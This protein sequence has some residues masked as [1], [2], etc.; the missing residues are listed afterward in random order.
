MFSRE[1]QAKP[2]FPTG[3]LGGVPTTQLI[4]PTHQPHIRESGYAHPPSFIISPAFDKDEQTGKRNLRFEFFQESESAQLSKRAFSDMSALRTADTTAQQLL[5][6][7]PASIDTLQ[8]LLVV[9][10]PDL[11]W[12]P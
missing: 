7:S 10:S 1:S 4:P 11:Q 12:F 5:K 2:S 6:T 3:I 8:Q 9:L